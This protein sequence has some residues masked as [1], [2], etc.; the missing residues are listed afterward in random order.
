[1]LSQNETSTLTFYIMTEIVTLMNATS[2]P[3]SSAE[4]SSQRPPVPYRHRIICGAILCVIS[5]AGIVGNLL[6]ILSV[7]LSKKLQ[8]PTNVLVVSLAIADLVTCLTIPF[9]VIVLLSRYDWPLSEAVC[10]V[11]VYVS[12]TSLCCSVFTLAAIAVIRWY[13]IT[14]SVHGNHGINTHGSMVGVAVVLWLSAGAAMTTPP[15]LGIGSVGYSDFYR[16]CSVTDYHPLNAY[17][18]LIQAFFMVLALIIIAIFYI[19]ILVYVIKS[20]KSLKSKF[21]RSADEIAKSATSDDDIEKR[22]NESVAIAAFNKREIAITKN[23]FVVVCVFVACIAPHSVNFIIPGASLPTLYSGIVMAINSSLNPMIYGLKHPNFR[24]VFR[25]ILS[26]NAAGIPQPSRLISLF[27]L[28]ST[29]S[30]G[31]MT[32]KSRK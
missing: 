16:L 21:R 6:V 15:A 9:Q 7:C 20:T 11:I 26:C 5:L 31:S 4:S 12:Y 27:T 22:E 25:C 30:S 8:T 17:Y 18:V 10:A 13:V 28:T 32:T 19:L 23:L 3:E 1:M 29:T 2:T 14:R 24:A